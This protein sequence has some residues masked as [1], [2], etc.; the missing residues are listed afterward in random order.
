MQIYL[1]LQ[2]GKFMQS[3]KAELNMQISYLAPTQWSC[4]RFNLGLTSD[5][6]IL[7]AWAADGQ[8]AE[9]FELILFKTKK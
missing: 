5:T 8:T 1:R 4:Y 7:P 6:N 2:D 3:V 9:T